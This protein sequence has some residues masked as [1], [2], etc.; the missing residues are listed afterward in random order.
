MV[1]FSKKI[2]LH[3]VLVAITLITLYTI[4][5]YNVEEKENQLLTIFNQTSVSESNVK[6]FN[7]YSVET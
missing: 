3:S 2:A 5:F 1:Y 7:A 4:E 6:P